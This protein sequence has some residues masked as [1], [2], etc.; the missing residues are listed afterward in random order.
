MKHLRKS[1][2]SRLT[3]AI[4][5]IIASFISAIFISTVANKGKDY[6]VISTPIITGHRILAS[7]ISVKHLNLNTS[8]SLYLSEAVDPV[9]MI[10]K[11]TLQVG[12]IVS[13]HDLSSE[14]DSQSNSAVPLSVRKVD[15][16][17]GINP[18]ESVDIYWLQDSRNGEEVIE[19]ILILGGVTLLTIDN[20]GD[21][22]SGDVGLSVAIEQTQ[23]LRILSAT[24]IGRIVVIRSNV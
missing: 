10:A 5:L 22:F 11:R 4:A 3:L 17:Q 21:S 6:W 15:V 12:E 23:V 18:G 16:T 24:T 19:P 20:S 8:S 13:V 7:D 1:P 2:S 14:V 9:G